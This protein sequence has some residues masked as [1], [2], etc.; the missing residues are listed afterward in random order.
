MYYL[1][2]SSEPVAV[3]TEGQFAG[4]LPALIMKT[5]RD[6]DG[7]NLG[8]DGQQVPSQVLFY[9]VFTGWK[10]AAQAHAADAGLRLGIGRFLDAWIM[11]EPW[12]GTVG[13]AHNFDFG[14]D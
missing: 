7:E 6:A 11:S 14:D 3:L 13:I 4:M 1:I 12:R 9:M 5:G 2:G 10:S 8:E